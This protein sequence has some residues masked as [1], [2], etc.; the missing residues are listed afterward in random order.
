MK[1][2]NPLNTSDVLLSDYSPCQSLPIEKYPGCILT[3]KE[4]LLYDLKA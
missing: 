4:H 2:A 3:K 1:R